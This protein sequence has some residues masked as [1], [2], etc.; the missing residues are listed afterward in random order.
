[1]WTR[2]RRVLRCQPPRR[3]RAGVARRVMRCARTRA[4]SEGGVWAARADR[5]AQSFAACLRTCRRSLLQASLDTVCPVSLPITPLAGGLSAAAWSCARAHASALRSVCARARPSLALALASLRLQPGNLLVN[6]NCDLKICDFGLARGIDDTH[7]NKLTEYVVTRWCARRDSASA[8]RRSAAVVVSPLFTGTCLS[9]ALHTRRPYPHHHATH[10]HTFHYGWTYRRRE[11]DGS[12]SHSVPPPLIPALLSV[13]GAA[14]P[15]LC[16]S[17]VAAAASQVPR[18][19]ATRRERELR[20]RHRH[21]VRRLHPR[22]V[23][24]A[25]SPLPRP[26]L[27]AAAPPHHRR[28]R[29]AHRGGPGHHPERAGPQLRPRVGHACSPRS[30][31]LALPVEGASGRRVATVRARARRRCR[32]S[33]HATVSP[34][35]DPS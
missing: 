26:R 12:D 16:R 11:P 29:H 32:L 9:L 5:R 8:S 24:R 3:R 18:A 13:R 34:F 14:R 30:G 1:M 15:H 23:P 4:R 21:V 17:V 28:A 10:T 25:Q 31:R 2:A 35:S 6:K 19:R 27:P 7:Q 33:T 22:R 20:R